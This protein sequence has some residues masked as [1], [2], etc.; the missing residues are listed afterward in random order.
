MSMDRDTAPAPAPAEP[1]SA[2]QTR[3]GSAATAPEPTK[4]RRSTLM[5]DVAAGAYGKRASVFDAGDGSYGGLIK[6]TDVGDLIDKP[7][8]RIDVDGFH[9]LLKARSLMTESTISRC[10]IVQSVKPDTSIKDFTAVC[11]KVNS[12]YKTHKD[13]I[14]DKE[15]ELIGNS[16]MCAVFTL[17][18]MICTVG[19]SCCVG[20]YFMSQYSAEL[21]KVTDD[22]AFKTALNQKYMNM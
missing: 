13:Y 8:K 10:E 20:P 9:E 11:N 6:A 2:G 12:A 1:T 22:E 17:Y 5:E 14:Q 7:T 18:C 3:R 4:K 16:T 15:L 19:I 21:E